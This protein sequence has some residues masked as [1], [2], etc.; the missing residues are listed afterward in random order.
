M[1]TAIG[2]YAAMTAVK[3][4]LG[5]DATFT[6]SDDAVLSTL[7]DGVNQWVESYTKRVL[8]PHSATEYILDGSSA[9]GGRVIEV[10]IGIRTLT[11]VEVAPYSG[12][13]LAAIPLADALLRPSALDLLLGRPAVD[14]WLT[15]L[16]AGIYRSWPSGYA[17]IRLTGTFGFAAI[18]DDVVS[19]AVSMAVRSWHGRQTGQ[20]GIIGT[21]EN[22]DT[23]VAPMP[24]ASDYQILK[25]Y[26]RHVVVIA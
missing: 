17:N 5:P 10:P 4:R 25:R 3:A 22:G 14:L 11:G 20:S 9:I 16:P 21:D 24:T 19:V 1:A 6:N 12:A 8:A 2:I 7:I 23:I 18:P 13:A 15:D 26:K